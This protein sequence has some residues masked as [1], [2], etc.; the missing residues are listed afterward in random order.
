[1]EGA[2]GV[3]GSAVRPS[4]A[5]GLL[6]L[7]AVE[8][9][10]SQADDD[11]E[12]DHKHEATS[13]QHRGNGRALA[14]RLGTQRPPRRTVP[15]LQAVVGNPPA[16]RVLSWHESIMKGRLIGLVG[17]SCIWA[18]CDRRRN[19]QHPPAIAPNDLPV[20]FV[21]HPVMAVTEQDQVT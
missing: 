15:V 4:V 21:H 5:E 18:E 16:L 7:G 1:M 19:R 2:G 14:G 6:E 10:N 3:A 20:A 11:D 8:R 13:D 9:E 12:H 17:T